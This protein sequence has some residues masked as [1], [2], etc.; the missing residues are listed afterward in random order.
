LEFR[1][2]GVVRC[3]A[4]IMMTTTATIEELRRRCGVVS[5]IPLPDGVSWSAW[6]SRLARKT[7][8]NRAFEGSDNDDDDT[9]GGV[10]VGVGGSRPYNRN[11][12]DE[13]D[14]PLDLILI[15]DIHEALSQYLGI[16]KTDDADAFLRLDDAF[17]PIFQDDLT[18]SV[19]RHHVS[20]RPQRPRGRG[21]FH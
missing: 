5:Q 8:M 1:G 6:A 4:E 3:P 2:G 13:P 9:N 21:F 10:G 11:I 16:P 18:F 14:F 12:L 17:F 7:P 20:I 19:W 15:G